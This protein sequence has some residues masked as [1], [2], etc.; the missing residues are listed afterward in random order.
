MELPKA[1][2]ANSDLFVTRLISG[3]NPLQGNSHF[4]DAMDRDTKYEDQISL[5]IQHTLKACRGAA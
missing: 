2:F 4:S 3:G 1:R 5:N